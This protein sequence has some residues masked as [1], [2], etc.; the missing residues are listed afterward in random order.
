MI[1]PFKQT[2]NYTKSKGISKI[3]FVLHGTLGAYEG[4][5]SWLLK[6]SAER[7]GTPPSSAHYVIGRNE[8]E[9]TQLVKNE[10]IAWHCG[11]PSNPNSRAKWLIPKN[12]L[13]Q[14]KSV[15]DHFIG[16]EFTTMYDMNKDGKITANEKS[17]TE[18]QYRCALQIIN[19][20]GIKP[21]KLLSHHEIC[22]YKSDDMYFAVLQLTTLLLN[23]RDEVV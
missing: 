15:N 23:Q 14:F 12:I 22:D 20:S 5:V 17:L 7:G 6:S 10:D 2:P 21:V 19:N 1:I 16:I 3:G 18:W 9:V 11:K 4:A 8:G 13:G